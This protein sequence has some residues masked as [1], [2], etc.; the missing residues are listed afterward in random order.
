MK[1][2]GYTN[3]FS[4][5][6]GGQIELKVSSWHPSDFQVDLVRIVSADPNPEGPGMDLRPVRSGIEGHYTSVA[7]ASSPGSYAVLPINGLFEEAFTL[8]MRFQPRLVRALPQAILSFATESGNVASIELSANGL[9][10]CAGEIA[11]T[12]PVKWNLLE[13]YELRLAKAGQELDLTCRRV[14]GDG[15]VTA[16]RLTAGL[17][18]ASQIILAARRGVAGGHMD[19][20]FNG[21]LESVKMLRGADLSTGAAQDLAGDQ[22]LLAHWDFSR[23]IPSEKLFDIGP[24]GRHGKT[25]N[26][27]ARGVR[28]SGW[29]GRE[30]SW[31]HAPEDY[32]A[33]HFH[34]GDLYDCGWDSD[35]VFDVP[36]DLPSGIYGFRLR[37]EDSEDI[38]PF[39]V[40][41]AENARKARLAVLFSTLTYMAYCNYP[42]TN[43]NAEYKA[44][45]SAWGSYPHHPALYPEFGRS[46]YDVHADGSGV[47]YSSMLRP[48]LLMR[49]GLFAYVDPRGSGLR[50]FPADMHLMAWLDAMGIEADVVTDHD[51]I[52]EGHDAIGDYELLLTVTHPEY[53]TLR[54]LD[55]LQTFVGEGG[56]FAYLGGNGFYWRVATSDA[57]PG[58]IEIR[59]GESGV[60]MWESEP[61]EAEQSFD[62][63]HGGLW[64]R[65]G[66]PPQHLVGVGMSAQGEFNGTYFRRT[67]AS[68]LPE[69]SWLFEGIEVDILGDF[70]FSG[71]G[72]AGF[73]LDIVDHALGS[74]SQTAVLA[75]S[76]CHSADYAC[77][78][79]KAWNPD[80]HTAAWKASQ[81]RADLALTQHAKGNYVFAASSI[82]FCGSL[83]ASNFNNN[84]STLLKNFIGKCLKQ[85]A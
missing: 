10:L 78:P 3:R 58:A 47:M 44:R 75:V 37:C 38:V 11:R 85:P 49:P 67:A 70:G 40:R 60:R 15:N 39:F 35:L 80:D 52:A 33:I 14:S 73:E 13:W 83:P 8:V 36:G 28:S 54:S 55:A 50:H 62:G 12:A 63:A 64:L 30:M 61:G 6:A 2:A 19:R 41:P 5:R 77:V 25:V 43:Y 1:L 69:H 71:G 56:N 66:R 22:P 4:V 23:D 9:T 20:F 48:Q 82:M 81:I 7:K 45:C 18:A 65:N 51:L 42:R 59:R 84:I 68:R 29:S 74:S 24:D 46:L 26:L 21:R 72:A 32:A 57:F 34:E 27:P 53:H 76:E 31:R 79:E 16:V 17:A